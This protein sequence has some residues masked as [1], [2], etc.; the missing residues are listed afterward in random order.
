[1]Y[2]G[3]IPDFWRYLNSFTLFVYKQQLFTLGLFCYLLHAQ[4]PSTDLVLARPHDLPTGT[5]P[6]CL[7]VDSA[8][9]AVGR[10]T[11]PARQSGTCCL[12]N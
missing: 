1:M 9:T 2:S 8:R 6:L 7:A 11:M 3:S 4:I 12:M 10:S 5:V